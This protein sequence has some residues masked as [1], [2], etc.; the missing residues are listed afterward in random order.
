MKK[1]KLINGIILTRKQKQHFF[2][3]D[4]PGKG[5]NNAGLGKGS[6]RCPDGVTIPRSFENYN[7]CVT[8]FTVVCSNTGTDTETYCSNPNL[9]NS[10]GGAITL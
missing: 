5:G 6:I 3:G 8:W 1:P 10:L 7:S 4:T 9:Y 2:A